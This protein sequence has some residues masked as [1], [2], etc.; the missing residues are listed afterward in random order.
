MTKP[1][2]GGRISPTGYHSGVGGGLPGDLTAN[3]KPIHYATGAFPGRPAT[4]RRY[5]PVRHDPSAMYLCADGHVKLLR[6][7]KISTGTTPAKPGP[8]T[9]Y[10]R[11]TAASTDQ[12][13]TATL[14]FSAL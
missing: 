3:G 5:G 9:G 7:E 2:E 12:L 10:A 13:G 1:D 8:Q 11:G 14:T 4:D 6:P